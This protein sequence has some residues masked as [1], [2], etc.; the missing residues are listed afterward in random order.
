MRLRTRP[1]PWA[2][3]KPAIVLWLQFTDSAGQI[4]ELGPLG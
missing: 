1:K 3:A 4:A 2:A